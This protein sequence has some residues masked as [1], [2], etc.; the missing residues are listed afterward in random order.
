MIQCR[1]SEFLIQM[2]IKN[3][4]IA[5]PCRNITTMR[6]NI[7]FFGVCA[8]ILLS[9]NQGRLDSRA[10]PFLGYVQIYSFLEKYSPL[11]GGGC[12]VSEA[13]VALVALEA[14]FQTTSDQV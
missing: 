8:E 7:A 14:F 5:V 1:F 3:A 2:C 13:L 4:F 11:G 10:G 12:L 9:R 6:R